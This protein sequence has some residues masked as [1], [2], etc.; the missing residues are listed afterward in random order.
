MDNFYAIRCKNKF[1]NYDRY[2]S[3]DA[4]GIPC[5][6]YDTLP[7]F[8]DDIKSFKTPAPAKHC[9]RDILDRASLDTS[10]LTVGQRIEL[11]R[12]GNN[13]KFYLVK[14]HIDDGTL[15]IDKVE[16]LSEFSKD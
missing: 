1:C 3:E 7:N 4:D 16:K 13:D 12:V 8:P 10:K 9:L 5:L 2:L 15:V 14:C 11:T 6:T